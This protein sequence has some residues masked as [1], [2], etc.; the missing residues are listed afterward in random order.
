MKLNGYVVMTPTGNGG[1]QAE[2]LL[3]ERPEKVL[4]CTF[5]ELK[6]LV[7]EAVNK[8]INGRCDK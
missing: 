8:I 7:N 1:Y 5:G 3:S 6:T 2:V 4:E